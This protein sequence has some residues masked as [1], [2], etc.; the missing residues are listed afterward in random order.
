M[1]EPLNQNAPRSFTSI[2]LGSDMDGL[3][4]TAV[5]HYTFILQGILLHPVEGII[6]AVLNVRKSNLHTA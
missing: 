3:S 5:G 1:S 6:T 2:H 4:R